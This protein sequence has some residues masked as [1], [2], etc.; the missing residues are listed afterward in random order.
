MIEQE[1]VNKGERTQAAVIAAAYELFVQQGYHGTSMRQI[2]ERAGLA[3]G[4]VYNHFAGKEAIFEA[5][6]LTYHPFVTVLPRLAELGD[7]YGNKEELLRAAAHLFMSEMQQEKGLF[8][9]LLIETIDL[10]GRHMADMFD[11]VLPRLLQF[12]AQLDSLPGEM[13]AQSP[14]AL[15]RSFVGTVTAY[16]V[17]EALLA[18][19]AMVRMGT[20]SVDDLMDIYLHGLLIEDGAV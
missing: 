6:L 15:F 2:A 13:R 14:A 8:N 17:T 11:V 12:Q 1:S 4:G 19:T 3:L 10:H 9:L 5:V 20:L 16:F 7:G 18:D